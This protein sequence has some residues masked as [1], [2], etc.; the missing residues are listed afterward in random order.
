MSFEP[1]ARQSRW[2]ALSADRLGGTV[3]HGDG[4]ACR[5]YVLKLRDF[6]P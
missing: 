2:T 1:R 3:R 6:S 4:I 5:E